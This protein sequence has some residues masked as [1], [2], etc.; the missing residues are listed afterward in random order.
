MKLKH[1]KI[2][3]ESQK[4]QRMI[5]KTSAEDPA[6]QQQHL[7]QAKEKDKETEKQV[8]PKKGVSNEK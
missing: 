6:K 1:L 3:D 4:L 2:R 7:E 8:T 5:R